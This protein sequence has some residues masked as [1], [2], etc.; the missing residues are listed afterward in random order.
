ML[1]LAVVFYT[2]S[3]PNPAAPSPTILAEYFAMVGGGAGLI[4][5]GVADFSI[6]QWG[7]H[8][9]ALILE[10]RKEEAPEKADSEKNHPK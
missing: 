1:I 2:A 10:S 8:L 7:M 9:E 6:H 5:G 3:N 4:L